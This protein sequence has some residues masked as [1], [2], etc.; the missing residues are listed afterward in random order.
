MPTHIF[1]EPDGAEFEVQYEHESGE[2]PEPPNIMKWRQVGADKWLCYSYLDNDTA[3]KW[4]W[5][6]EQMLCEE[7]R[8]PEDWSNATERYAA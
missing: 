1:K 3:K 4:E 8:T 5:K 2:D 7:A 6:L